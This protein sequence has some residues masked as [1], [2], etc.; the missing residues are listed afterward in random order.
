MMP[1]LGLLAIL[2]AI[3]IAWRVHEW[4][5]SQKAKQRYDNLQAEW[6]YFSCKL[7]DTAQGYRDT[8]SFQSRGWYLPDQQEI[9]NNLYVRVTDLSAEM[10]ECAEEF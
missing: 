2:T 10:A 4:R 7:R 9:L 8:A 6:A 5:E 1:A 3:F